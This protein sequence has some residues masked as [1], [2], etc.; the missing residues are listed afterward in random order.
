MLFVSIII[1]GC[2]PMDFILSCVIYYM[3]EFNSDV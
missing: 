1:S 2:N 3:D